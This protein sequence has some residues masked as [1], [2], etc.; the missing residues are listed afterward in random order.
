MKLFHRP[1]V[2]EAV[3][4]PVPRVRYRLRAGWAAMKNPASH[5]AGT[6]L[7]VAPFFSGRVV[8]SSAPA[9]C[10]SSTAWS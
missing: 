2:P 4:S 9:V 1:L 5:S 6:A 3:Q 7:V 10:A 8:Q